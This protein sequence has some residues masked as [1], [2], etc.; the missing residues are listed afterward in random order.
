MVISVW[1]EGIMGLFSGIFKS[2]SEREVNRIK[3][4]VNKIDALDASMQ[5]L[6]DEE[7]QAK[8]NEFKERLIMEKL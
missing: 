4:I 2:Y 3:P 1:K 5:K 7:L 8:T 6:S